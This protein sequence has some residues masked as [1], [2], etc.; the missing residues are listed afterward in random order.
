MMGEKEDDDAVRKQ[1]LLTRV[2]ELLKSEKE[3]SGRTASTSATPTGNET[4]I[5]ATEGGVSNRN[6]DFV[7]KL[8]DILKCC[9]SSMELQVCRRFVNWTDRD[10]VIYGAGDCCR[11]CE[12]IPRSP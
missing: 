3:R 11:N 10:L 4:S 5:D 1:R 8:W 6:L 9:G 2:D 12:H 7:A